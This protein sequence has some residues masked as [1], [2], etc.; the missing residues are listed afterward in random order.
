[1]TLPPKNPSPTSGR[2]LQPLPPGSVRIG[3]E[4]GRRIELTIAGNLLKLDVHKDFLAPLAKKP[5][6]Y[7][8][9]GL[10]LKA[11]SHFAAAG[12]ADAAALR[13]RVA[14]ALV[15]AQEPDGYI[16]Y[17]TPGHKLWDL[18]DGDEVAQ[19]ILGLATHYDLTGSQPSL[20]AAA[21]RY[22]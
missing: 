22:T 7:V 8:G 3:G 1:M 14:Q 4:I 18:F 9:V 6:D 21:Y 20:A 2:S 17:K 12:H 13:D 10:L 19:I 5:G 16:G 11:A 15:R